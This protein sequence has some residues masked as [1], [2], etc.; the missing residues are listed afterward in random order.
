MPR[1]S[2]VTPSLGEMYPGN[3]GPPDETYAQPVAAAIAIR[4]CFS[5]HARYQARVSSDAILERPS[6]SKTLPPVSGPTPSM[7]ATP[8]VSDA[9][10]VG[11]RT[12][13][14]G[15]LNAGAA[16]KSDSMGVV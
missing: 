7:S 8:M 1:L 9:D 6:G 3:S 5:S 2:K 4:E 12:T 13:P 11:A 15:A 16:A 14:A 10:R